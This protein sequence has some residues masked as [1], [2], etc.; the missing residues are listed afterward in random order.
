MSVLIQSWLLNVFPPLWNLSKYPFPACLRVWWAMP[1]SLLNFF[2]IIY[3]T[4]ICSSPLLGSVFSS[5][6]WKEVWNIQETFRALLDFPVW[7]KTAGA[8]GGLLPSFYIQSHPESFS[9]IQRPL[10]ILT[11]SHCYLPG[12][13]KLHVLRVHVPLSSLN[14]SIASCFWV[15]QAYVPIQILKIAMSPVWQP[16]S[17]NTRDEGSRELR[18][19]RVKEGSAKS[20]GT[21]A[22]HVAP[23][24]AH[25]IQLPGAGGC[26]WPQEPSEKRLPR[27][28]GPNVVGQPLSVDAAPQGGENGSLPYSLLQIFL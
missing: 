5:V 10:Y 13:S 20:G 17:V 28:W 6:W 15:T 23:F 7:V 12:P 25:C 27:S 2:P 4:N 24:T 8:G 18:G 3:L 11:S 26:E 19:G 14:V 1:K 9:P 16:S 21:P 22:M